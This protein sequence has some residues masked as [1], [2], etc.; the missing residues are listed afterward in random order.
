MI[1]GQYHYT[2]QYE[3]NW[4]Y[5]YRKKMRKQDLIKISTMPIRYTLKGSVRGKSEPSA[6]TKP[7]GAG[8]GPTVWPRVSHP[9]RNG[10]HDHRRPPYPHQLSQNGPGSFTQHPA[11]SGSHRPVSAPPYF[12]SPGTHLQLQ[13]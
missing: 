11:A 12:L 13:V 4:V 10:D 5:M 1:T 8:Y 3:T 9:P 2:K 6:G 7:C